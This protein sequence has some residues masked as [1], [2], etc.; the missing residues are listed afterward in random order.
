MYITL[1]LLLCFVT[2][3]IIYFVFV[4]ADETQE[5]WTL[6]GKTSIGLNVIYKI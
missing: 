2:S 6:K 1:S 5:K 3:T 4:G